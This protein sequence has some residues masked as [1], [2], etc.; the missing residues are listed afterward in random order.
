MW[1]GPCACFLM[2]PKASPIQSIRY[3]HMPCHALL[4]QQGSCDAPPRCAQT[5]PKPAPYRIVASIRHSVHVLRDHRIS[6]QLHKLHVSNR[7]VATASR[8]LR[9]NGM[10]IAAVLAPFC[11]VC[12]V[13]ESHGVQW[14]RGCKRYR[15]LCC[16]RAAALHVAAGVGHGHWRG[17]LRHQWSQ[18]PPMTMT[19]SHTIPPACLEH[20]Q[21]PA[22]SER[23]LQLHLST[24]K[25]VRYIPGSI[26]AGLVAVG[27][28]PGGHRLPRHAAFSESMQ[29]GASS[30]TQSS[31]MAIARAILPFYQ[32]HSGSES[33]TP[34][35]AHLDQ[36]ARG[37]CRAWRAAAVPLPPPPARIRPQAVRGSRV[38]ASAQL[39]AL[40]KDVT[41]KCYGG[42]IQR[43]KKLLDKQREGK[44]RLKALGKVS[45]P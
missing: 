8:Q 27:P 22:C 34:H 17:R 10:G 16:S 23:R 44:K 29:P 20:E 26:S 1:Q 7:P 32:A 3:R 5:R 39:P 37:G 31:T 45:V 14:L 2:P 41:A 19:S 38:V 9:V 13:V 12:T 18:A 21:H 42:D 30:C 4:R 33:R 24:G 43:K 25:T 11:I 28:F 6:A 15:G 40:R 35:G 36:L